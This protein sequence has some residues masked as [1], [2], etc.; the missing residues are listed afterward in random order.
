VTPAWGLAG[1][2][3]GAPPRNDVVGPDGETIHPLKLRARSFKKGTRVITR[4]GGGGG[5][6]DPRSRPR[7]EVAEDVRWGLV[8]SEQ[9]A[10]V[11]GME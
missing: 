7:E 4:T 1:G 10:K 5:Y 8:S 9:A 11:Y 6:G 3:A 2:G